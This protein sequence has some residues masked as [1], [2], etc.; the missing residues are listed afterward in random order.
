MELETAVRKELLGREAVTG[1]VQDKVWKFGQLGHV[2]VEGRKVSTIGAHSGARALV[3]YRDGGWAEPG[4]VNT[5]EFPLLVVEAWADCSR[6]ARG[7]QIEDDAIDNAYALYRV[8]DPILHAPRRGEWWGGPPGKG[9]RVITSARAAE[10][11]H[12]TQDTRLT[13]AE[14]DYLGSAARVTV[15][16]RVQV[17]H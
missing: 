2:E 16:Y 1:Y 17:A 7:D 3:V 4:V 8:V 5:A 11:V 9:L 14:R 6:D 13:N 12:A 10:P 15:R